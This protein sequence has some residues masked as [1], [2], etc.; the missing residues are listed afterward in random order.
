MLNVLKGFFVDIVV[1]VL[2]V[3]VLLMSSGRSVVA[4]NTNN[5]VIKSFTPGGQNYSWSYQ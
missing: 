1:V 3:D 5:Q 4:E 2:Y